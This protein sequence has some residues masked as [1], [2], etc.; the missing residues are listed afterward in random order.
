MKSGTTSFQTVKKILTSRSLKFVLALGVFLLPTLSHASTHLTDPRPGETL[1]GAQ[2]DVSWVSRNEESDAFWI[3]AGS[4]PG[5][6]NYH[7]SGEIDS[8]TRNWQL[9]VPTDGSIVHL[10]FWFRHK[11]HGWEFD[12]HE[13]RAAQRASSDH[14]YILTP[15]PRSILD[16]SSIEFDLHEGNG[17]EPARFWL[18]LGSTRGAQDLHNSGE[19]VN[20]AL[21]T[22][23]L[24]YQVDELPVDGRLI[25]ARLW[26]LNNDGQWI[27]TDS[28]YIAN[29]GQTTPY[30]DAPV[31]ADT[32]GDGLSLYTNLFWTDPT[33][34]ALE[35]WIY[36]GTSPG[37]SDIYNTGSID[38]H[39]RSERVILPQNDRRVHVRF[40]YRLP[41]AGWAF[42]DREFASSGG[43]RSRAYLSNPGDNF[44]TNGTIRWD[45]GLWDAS[46]YWLQI[47]S[48]RHASDIYDSGLLSPETR[49][50]AFSDWPTGTR[51]VTL[52]FFRSDTGW[53][54][55]DQ[56]YTVSNGGSSDGGA[57]A[58]GATSGG[59]TSGGT[60]SGG[61]DTSGTSTSGATSGGTTSGGTTSGGTSSG[62]TTSG[63]ATTGGST[64]ADTA[65]HRSGQTFLT[66][67]ENNSTDNYHVYRHDQPITAANVAD[68][69]RLTDRWGPLDEN[70]SVH[71][72]ATDDAP[73]RFVIEDLA[74]PVGDDKGLFVHT[75]SADNSGDA[76]YAVTVVNAGVEENQIH[77]SFG[78]FSESADTP[79][80]V[81]VRS[82]N[83]GKGRIYTQFRDYAKWNPTLNGYAY[84]FAVALPEN[85]DPATSYP[86]Q[87][88]LHAYGGSHKFETATEFDWPVIQ[89]FPD[90]PLNHTANIIPTWWYGFSDTHDYRTT[91]TNP[92]TGQIINFTE[93]R[94]LDSVDFLIDHADFNVNENLIY[95]FG[96]SMGASGSLSLGIRYGNVF[97]GIY[98]SQPMTNYATNPVFQEELARLWGDST[99]NLPTV[100]R[101][102]YA[103]PLADYSA[104]GNQATGV[105]DWNN[106]QQQLLERRGEDMA[107]L[108][109]DFGKL[110]TILD[111]TTQGKPIWESL[112]DANVGFAGVALAGFDH[113]W[114]GFAGVINNL[115]PLFGMQYGDD[116]PWLYPKNESF[117]GISNATDSGDINPA[118]DNVSDHYNQS[119]LWSTTRFNFDQNIVDSPEGYEVS[120]QSTTIDQVADIT[121]RRT[122][123][124][125]P[126]PGTLC[127]W[128][129]IDLTNSNIVSAA[130]SALIVDA[131]SLATAE[132]VPILAGA[133]IR[134]IIDC[135]T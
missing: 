52:W 86:L 6:R 133:G 84:N 57:T 92:E 44:F 30:L 25:H 58:G 77:A 21:L 53:L 68:A 8:A 116:A 31:M 129:A 59:T 89:L 3:Y 81:L 71:P 95:A 67:Q 117:I 34:S 122:S 87:V 22:P 109:T 121:P 128:Q 17:P 114:M 41:G 4:Q 10:R 102:S 48:E 91:G 82:E 56:T 43:T 69:T 55:D 93:H 51:Y 1:D 15:Q 110:D 5:A 111:W 63:G 119:I 47:G 98:A 29:A 120:I 40:Y 74:E 72:I 13:Y 46:A 37:S 108:I 38:G 62:G 49:E 104:G 124:F 64:A 45:D 73:T 50:Y 127:G 94:V 78:P 100:H 97:A 65:F 9:S 27:F 123:Q 131:D 99:L 106:Q 105:W 61:S 33:N 70:T 96:H 36:V 112:T 85:Y 60:T 79:E 130:N 20:S 23:S 125:N 2:I 16:G 90:D 28:R 66:W 103:A 26:W 24:K 35:Y 132:D 134:L 14:A 19:L 83:N 12:D 76:W 101:G 126:A 75:T 88:Q 113:S 11:V 80:P 118:D 7:D 42:E 39:Q 135:S 54:H 107:F 32:L 18:Y 115:H